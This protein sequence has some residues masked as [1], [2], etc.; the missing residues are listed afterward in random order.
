MDRHVSLA[1]S[2]SL[3]VSPKFGG[4]SIVRLARKKINMYIY[5]RKKKI[6]NDQISSSRTLTKL[7]EN[8]YDDLSEQ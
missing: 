1:S 6:T 7:N 2:S 8:C 4:V 5:K 3:S